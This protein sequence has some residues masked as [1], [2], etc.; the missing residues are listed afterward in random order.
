MWK[1]KN[2]VKSIY[3]AAYRFTLTNSFKNFRE[4]KRFSNVPFQAV[5]WFHEF[6]FNTTPQRV[7][8]CML[9]NYYQLT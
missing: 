1:N 7:V 2:F 6:F 9:Y 4:I 8:Q 3:S 5:Y